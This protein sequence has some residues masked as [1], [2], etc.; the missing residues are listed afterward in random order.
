MADI[1]VEVAQEQTINATV[2]NGVTFD[3]EIVKAGGGGGGGGG[4]GTWGTITGTLSDQADLQ[5]ALTSRALRT[6]YENLYDKVGARGILSVGEY[7]DCDFKIG[8]YANFSACL[9]AAFTASQAGDKITI[10]P[11]SVD[12]TK[13][14]TQ[15]V[16]VKSGVT[17]HYQEG[18]ETTNADS[19]QIDYTL[20]QV[21]DEAS[22]GTASNTVYYATAEDSFTYWNG[23][24]YSNVVNPVGFQGS[25]ASANDSDFL[26]LDNVLHH[27]N[28]D[29]P[30]RS[31]LLTGIGSAGYRQFP[32]GSSGGVSFN[33]NNTN[34]MFVNF[35]SRNS[36][37]YN[38]FI[39]SNSFGSSLA[40]TYNFT[41]DSKHVTVTSGSPLTQ[42]SEGD[43]LRTDTGSNVTFPIARIISNSVVE[44]KYAWVYNS[45]SSTVK[46]NY[47]PRLIE[48]NSRWGKTAV[49]DT[50]GGGPWGFSYSEN[51]I[52]ENSGGYGIG[53]TNWVDSVIIGAIG[54]N[55]ING[56]GFERAGGIKLI[57]S[58]F[59]NNGSKG[60]QFINGAQNNDIVECDAWGNDDG[61]QDANFSADRGQNVGNRWLNCRA[62]S[63]NQHGMRI[64]GLRNGTIEV[65][66]YN[67]FQ[68][69][70]GGISLGAGV[71]VTGGTY[72]TQFT[73]F[74]CKTYDDQSIVTQDNGMYLDDNLE[75]CTMDYF[76]VDTIGYPSLSFP[77]RSR[78]INGKTLTL[79]AGTER[80][81]AQHITCVE[82]PNSAMQ[83]EFA[84][85]GEMV[86]G[87]QVELQLT[88]STQQVL[89][90]KRNEG[91]ALTS[92][93][94][95]PPYMPI[96][97]QQIWRYRQGFGAAARWTCVSYPHPDQGLSNYAD[98]TAAAAGGVVIGQRYRT[99]SI[100][101]TRVT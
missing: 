66:A 98:D 14:V 43:T 44:L 49:D 6:E 72:K 74:K 57:A 8:D 39:G 48:I 38:T 4:G 93:G 35:H 80:E 15:G 86:N 31:N 89:T 41:K 73:S 75:D 13:F 96:R 67:N 12:G 61:F 10:V 18:V 70:N 37:R 51:C 23:A 101:K 26:V 36:A 1:N 45:L 71:A 62:F 97:S 46:K 77:Q 30:T 90:V 92:V 69:R 55:C 33:I 84:R 78:I 17:L 7:N 81:I 99:G 76:N 88:A 32:V 91:D 85:G 54:R 25:T 87:N 60:C 63:N 50:H 82:I 47:R 68:N 83:I 95:Y 22:R 53:S 28:A 100:L 5:S 65:E 64:A 21:A 9:N 59:Y 11:P 2:S 24:S 40:G 79:V 29:F 16:T 34:I 3:V 19:P 58:K 27:G 42:L 52:Y 56:A 20:I 94:Y